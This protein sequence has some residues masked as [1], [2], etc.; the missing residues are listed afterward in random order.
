M[1]IIKKRLL[2]L[3]TV[4]IIIFNNIVTYAEEYE[5]AAQDSSDILSLQSKS[6]ILM[7]ASTGRILYE[8]YQ[9]KDI[10]VIDCNHYHI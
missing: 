1:K 2:V 4:I 10:G 9:K 3:L 8:T 5:D 6:A 7:E